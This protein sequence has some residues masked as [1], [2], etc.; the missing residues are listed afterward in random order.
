MPFISLSGAVVG[1]INGII[2]WMRGSKTDANQ[3]MGFYN[4]YT[5]DILNLAEACKAEIQIYQEH[6]NSNK[7]MDDQLLTELS[8]YHNSIMDFVEKVQKTPELGNH[9]I[10]ASASYELD[11]NIE[12]KPENELTH[13]I[14]KSGLSREIVRIIIDDYVTQGQK[15]GHFN[16]LNEKHR[17]TLLEVKELLNERKGWGIN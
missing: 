9:P 12:S 15:S 3:N 6:F 17:E 14:L 10:L 16:S 2:S 13:S 11:K 8:N 7:K 1:A 4:K 5:K